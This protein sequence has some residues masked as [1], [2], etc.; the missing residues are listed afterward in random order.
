M[1]AIPFMSNAYHTQQLRSCVE[2]EK[3]GSKPLGVAATTMA[4]FTESLRLVDDQ[5][6]RLQPQ[7]LFINVDTDNILENVNHFIS[8][9]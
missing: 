3:K 9:H 4:A 5:I 7:K 2:Q 8:R 6:S 1:S